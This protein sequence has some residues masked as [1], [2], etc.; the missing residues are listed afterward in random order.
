VSLADVVER[1]IA[2]TTL[3]AA[4]A[5]YF[6]REF[7]FAR[8]NAYGLDASLL[9]LT[10]QDYVLRSVDALFVPLGALVLG[11]L[12]AVTAHRVI[13]AYSRSARSV[14][15]LWPLGMTLAS[16]GLALLLVGVYAIFGDVPSLAQTWYLLP[17]LAPGIGMLLLAY[18]A[19]LARPAW[20]KEAGTSQTVKFLVGSFLI[21][22]LF[23]TGSVYARALGRGRGEAVLDNL[24][25]RPAVTVYSQQRLL[26]QGPGIRE[27]TLSPG[28][29]S[30]IPPSEPE[31]SYRYDGLRLI[32]R[33]G[34]NYFLLPERYSRSTGATIM[35]K[36]SSALRFEFLRGSS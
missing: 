23:W 18:G 15:W 27:T 3:L 16:T 19:K 30:H 7:T 32:I 2:P 28:Q 25:A 12:V 24:S 4:F 14:H 1:V 5:Y 36:E 13:D 6:G 9:G 10:A 17:S 20:F 33:S 26:L 11:A 35:L 34:G 29:S 8:V 21:L 31:F 22:S